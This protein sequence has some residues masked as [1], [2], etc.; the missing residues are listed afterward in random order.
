MKIESITIEG[1][2]SFKDKT[3]INLKDL[4]CFIGLNGSGKTAAL[5]ALIRLFGIYESQRTVR[6][7]DFYVKPGEGLESQGTRSLYIEAKLV[8]PELDDDEES[9]S[10]PLFFNE[11]M[12]N[13]QG[14]DPYCR[15][16][17]EATWENGN[18][19]EG[20]IDQEINWILSAEEKPK[21]EDKR[22]VRSSDRNN[23]QVNYVPATREPD[24]QIKQT[25]GTFM[26]QLINYIKWEDEFKKITEESS[27]SIRNKFSSQEG[28]K[29]M[30]G[31]LKK[32]WEKYFDPSGRLYKNIS[33]SPFDTDF[34]EIVS[35]AGIFFSPSE[36]GGEEKTDKLSEGMKSLLYLT[37]ISTLFSVKNKLTENDTGDSGFDKDKMKF[38]TLSVFA[39]EEPENHLSPH[40]IGRI[41]QVL[42]EMLDAKG[43]Q[44]IL[45]SHSPS[46][47]KRIDPEEVLY[48]RIGEERKTSVKK[49]ILPKKNDAM[50][51][52]VKEAVR[53]YP[54]LYFSQMV[55][56]GEGDSEA[57][58]IPKIAEAL[59]VNIDISFISFVPL[60]GRHVNHFWK[61]LTDLEIPYITLLD[62]DKGRTGGR[63][64]R[65]K[66]ALDQLSENGRNVSQIKKLFSD[67]DN[68]EENIINKLEELDVFFSMPLDIDYSMMENYLDSYKSISSEGYGPSIPNSEAI[69]YKEEVKSAIASVLKKK[70]N[71][72]VDVSEYDEK[73]IE[74]YFWYRYL[75]LN[76]SKPVSHI[77]ALS[78]INNDALKKCP[79]E[80][81]RLIE[82]I[83]SKINI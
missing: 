19:I 56:L 27:K 81:E 31:E 67:L 62:Y 7:N 44:V 47:I 53:A 75:F 4:T 74:Y 54:E 22:K 21:E 16:R 11:M 17:I 45:T 37:L 9:N 70:S 61:L 40:Y 8:F 63:E 64:G 33:I 15:I 39:I 2:K 73:I 32:F 49:I 42:K 36:T 72:Q 60:G 68:N 59:G 13:G 43:V 50:Y 46:I 34:D 10:V 12:I 18:S 38:P 20:N 1:F 52:Y 58:V 76:R 30:Q 66:Y 24:E 35:H 69:N 57:V 3:T 25:A 5:E 79:P 28:I 82:K 26:H 48:F 14:F 80:L 65:I 83:K 51:K 78:H 71:D 6:K 77:L 29:T 41:M 55:V 23:I